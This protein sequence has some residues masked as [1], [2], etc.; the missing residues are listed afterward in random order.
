[1]HKILVILT[2]LS[3]FLIEYI[4]S[5]QTVAY[6]LA[7]EV[8]IF[9]CIRLDS[10][11]DPVSAYAHDRNQNHQPIKFCPVLPPALDRPFS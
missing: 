8:H 11:Q 2:L 4:I 6:G 10:D 7:A 5:S 3:Y 9:E 1:M